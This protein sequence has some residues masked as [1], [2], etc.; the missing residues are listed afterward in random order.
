[1]I[2]PERRRESMRIITKQEKEAFDKLS[3]KIDANK[4]NKA[5]EET[6]ARW[7]TSDA[8]PRTS[9]PFYFSHCSN[10]GFKT[11]A[12]L[13]EWGDKCPKCGAIIV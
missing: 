10:C 13:K 2:H 12:V 8:Y 4:L 9:Y 11:A 3:T 1:M 7:I 6:V 5:I